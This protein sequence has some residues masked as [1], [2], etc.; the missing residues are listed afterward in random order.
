MVAGGGG[1]GGAEGEPHVI[2]FVASDFH[3]AADKISSSLINGWSL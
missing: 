2:S 3:E 1:D